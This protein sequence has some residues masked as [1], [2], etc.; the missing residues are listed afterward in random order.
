MRRGLVPRRPS[1]EADAANDSLE[2]RD[3]VVGNDVWVEVM[4]LLAVCRA[5]LATEVRVVE[6]ADEELPQ[7]RTGRPLGRG[8]RFV[9]R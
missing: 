1:H 2:R 4:N 5:H 8:G 3:V 9:P 6:Q 7:V